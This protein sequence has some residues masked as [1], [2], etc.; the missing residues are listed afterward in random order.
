MADP[1]AR[2]KGLYLERE[3]PDGGSVATIGPIPRFARTPPLPGRLLRPSMDA[4]EI[5]AELKLDAIDELSRAAPLRFGRRERR[6]GASDD[7]SK[8]F[9]ARAARTIGCCSYEMK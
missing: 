7:S 3:H 2:A 9:H 4:R 8:E 1:W 6:A 5:L